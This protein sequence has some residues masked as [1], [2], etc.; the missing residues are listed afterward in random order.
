MAIATIGDLGNMYIPP[1][2]EILH[3][4]SPTLKTNTGFICKDSVCTL[5]V[6]WQ[7]PP[8]VTSPYKQP[9]N[10][11]Y[12]LTLAGTTNSGFNI[13]ID[14]IFVLQKGKFFNY[15]D[16]CGTITLPQSCLTGTPS[17][18]NAKLMTCG[19][20]GSPST[21]TPS[22]ITSNAHGSNILAPNVTTNDC[23]CKTTPPSNNNWFIKIWC[24]LFRCKDN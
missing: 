12:F 15:N 14:S 19:G 22:V 17:L 1:H 9:K 3:V 7:N 11:K 23:S 13:S 18:M 10:A 4:Y 24:W 8:T 6:T 2:K 16:T 20:P 21:G 5:R